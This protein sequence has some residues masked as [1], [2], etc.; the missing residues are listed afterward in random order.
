MALIP[1]RGVPPWA[2]RPV[3]STSS[4]SRPLWPRQG[5]LPVGSPTTAA[6]GTVARAPDPAPPAI[7]PATRCSAPSPAISS[8]T[9]AAR[10]TDPALRASR[11]RRATSAAAIAA[12][13]P[14]MSTAPRPWRRPSRTSPEKPTP[15]SPALSGTVSVCPQ[16]RRRRPGSPPARVQSRLGRPGSTSISSAVR[17]CSARYS[18]S[19]RATASS[20]RGTPGW[21]GM[22]TSRAARATSSAS[23]IGTRRRSGVAVEGARLADLSP[24]LSGAAATVGGAPQPVQ[25]AR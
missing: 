22:R 24:A 17:P 1:L 18:P 9:T 7:Q 4:H 5:R 6:S 2:A 21:L 13:A 20:C 8:S 15:G 19:A 16:S 3:N 12:N 11:R 23:S 14:F 10:V 25:R